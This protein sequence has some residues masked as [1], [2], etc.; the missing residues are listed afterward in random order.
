METTKKPEKVN[1]KTS[2]PPTTS[3]NVN[4]EEENKKSGGAGKNSKIKLKITDSDV[5][6]PIDV[7]TTPPPTSKTR[8]SST[9]SNKSSPTPAKKS[10]KQKQLLD[11]TKLTLNETI[12]SGTCGSMQFGLVKESTTTS[13]ISTVVTTSVKAAD[14]SGCGSESLVSNTSATLVMPRINRSDDDD[15]D[16]DLDDKQNVK[17][18]KLN[19]KRDLNAA[20]KS[21]PVAQTTTT[22]TNAI[23]IKN[24]IFNSKQ[25]QNPSQNV[26]A[27]SS[28][29]SG[30]KIVFNEDDD[31]NSN[32]VD[33]EEI[34]RENKINAN[35]IG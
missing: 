16:D 1:L 29:I 8:R 7:K 14:S 24:R 27:K 30:F 32:D 18:F 13:L 20:A 2:P 6:D 12:I 21:P 17:K 15:D 23:V 5:E 22:T 9:G 10:P 4:H 28:K 31:E 35:E 33:E 19:I 26:A 3:N 25:S 11:E 34:I